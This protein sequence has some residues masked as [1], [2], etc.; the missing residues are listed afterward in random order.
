MIDAGRGIGEAFTVTGAGPVAAMPGQDRDGELFDVPRDAFAAGLAAA[1]AEGLASGRPPP[2]GLIDVARAC[3]FLELRPWPMTA[4]DWLQEVDPEGDIARLTAAEREELVEA[5][6]V[7]PERYLDVQ[8]WSEG[9]AVMQDAL[10]D[11]VAVD[12]PGAP[13]WARMAAP[14]EGARVDLDTRIEVVSFIRA[15]MTVAGRWRD[16]GGT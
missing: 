7:R 16:G 8:F 3:G 14:A 11:G 9:T 6:G 12:G 5:S 15:R 10:D 4:Q 13:F 2:A 1:I